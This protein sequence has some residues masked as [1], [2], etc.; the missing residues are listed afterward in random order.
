M[1]AI[2]RFVEVKLLV[3]FLLAK[4]RQQVNSPAEQR[5]PVTVMQWRLIAHGQSTMSL[6]K[7]KNGCPNLIQ[8]RASQGQIALLSRADRILS[9]GCH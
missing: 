1:F 8:A 3:E 9:G 5:F 4:K 7:T 6:V 2:P